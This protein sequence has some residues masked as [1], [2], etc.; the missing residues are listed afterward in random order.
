MANTTLESHPSDTSGLHVPVPSSP[1]PTSIREERTDP[2]Q[3]AIVG[4]AAELP[5]GS[6]S[7]KNLDYKSFAEFLSNKG[8]AYE[9]IPS[10]RFNLRS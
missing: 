4:V 5:S 8:E 3:V 10:E 1:L 2:L 6:Y 7:H 9:D